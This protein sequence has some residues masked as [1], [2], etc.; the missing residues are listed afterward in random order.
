MTLDDDSAILTLPPSS[1]E[2]LAPGNLGLSPSS[3]CR[4][5]GRYDACLAN[6]LVQQAPPT[7]GWTDL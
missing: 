5:A 4:L 2:S 3:S 1:P 6:Q 7:L